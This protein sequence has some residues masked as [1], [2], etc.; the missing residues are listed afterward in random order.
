[1]HHCPG[2]C[3]GTV[4]VHYSLSAFELRDALVLVVGIGVFKLPKLSIHLPGGAVLILTSLSSISH[5][6]H[7]TKVNFDYTIN[8]CKAI[9]KMFRYTSCYSSDYQR[10]VQV[11]LYFYIASHV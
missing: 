8:S 10:N 9:C 2:H 5:R 11:Q 4:K 3:V 6:V 7:Q 1:M